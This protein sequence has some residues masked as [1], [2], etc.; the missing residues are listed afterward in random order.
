MKI[1]HALRQN[2][3]EKAAT[4]VLTLMTVETTNDDGQ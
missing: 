4:A 3:S 2:A 1:H